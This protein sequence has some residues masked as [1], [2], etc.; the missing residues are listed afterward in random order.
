MQTAR[1]TS[2]GQ[3]TIPSAVRKA[4]HLKAGD[5]V[6]FF[7]SPDGE[8]ILFPKNRPIRDLEGCVTKLDHIVTI[9]EM[10]EGIADAVAESFLRSVGTLAGLEDDASKE[11]TK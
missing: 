3:I 10:N 8:Y 7:K 6:D 4:L 2:K 11:E 1:V 5:R 9:E